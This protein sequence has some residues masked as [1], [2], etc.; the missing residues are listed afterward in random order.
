[1]F[2][3]TLFGWLTAAWA[4]LTVLLAAVV[5]L[6]SITANHEDTQ[7]FLDPAEAAFEAEQR[8]ISALMTRLSGYVRRLALADAALL[9]VMLGWVSVNVARSF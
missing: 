3:L 6:R 9:A 2:G 5:I 1:M 4:V 7:I 8:D